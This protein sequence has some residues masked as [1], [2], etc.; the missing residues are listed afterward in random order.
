M[1]LAQTLLAHMPERTLVLQALLP[2]QKNGV[3]IK[4]TC[5][6]EAGEAE[7]QRQR[8]LATHP[9]TANGRPRGRPCKE[10]AHQA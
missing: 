7:E 2:L 1:A 8:R 10:R 5:K 4:V 3:R 9:S 6:G